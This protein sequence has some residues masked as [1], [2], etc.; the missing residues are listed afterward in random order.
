MTGDETLREIAARP[1]WRKPAEEPRPEP[2]SVPSKSFKVI[3]DPDDPWGPLTYLDADE[4][5]KSEANLEAFAKGRT[6]DL[7]KHDVMAKMTSKQPLATV[8]ASP[9]S[10]RPSTASS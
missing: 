10:R 9:I 7:W 5:Q 6:W 2:G 8:F 1:R 3:T 4:G